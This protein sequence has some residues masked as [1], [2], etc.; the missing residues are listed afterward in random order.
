MDMRDTA[1]HIEN[2]Q[3]SASHPSSSCATLFEAS[4]T[5]SQSSRAPNTTGRGRRS[6]RNA[7]I[8][9]PLHSEFSVDA[10][11]IL[12]PPTVSQHP[13]ALNGKDSGA[14]IGTVHTS[15][16][17]ID[18]WT[19]VYPVFDIQNPTYPPPVTLPHP[20]IL[21]RP[22]HPHHP[23]YLRRS[24]P[25]VF[26]LPLYPELNLDMCPRG[27]HP[28]LPGVDLDPRVE[29]ARKVSLVPEDFAPFDDGFQDMVNNSLKGKFG[30]RSVKVCPKSGQHWFSYN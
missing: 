27:R 14:V 13:L 25:Y 8:D 28:P 7:K 2:Y 17:R 19:S 15:R 12:K 16:I 1:P 20:F 4:T 21:D 3:T 5:K 24:F 29:G 6:R 9:I 26:S 18:D 30:V 10:N 23:V 22:I 11:H